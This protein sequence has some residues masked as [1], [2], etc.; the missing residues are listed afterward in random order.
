MKAYR[1]VV[2]T[3]LI[4]GAAVSAQAQSI[5]LNDDSSTYFSV[6]RSYTPAHLERA[7]KNYTGCLEST[8]VGVVESALAHVARMKLIF[9]AAESRKL[10]KQIEFLTVN[11]QTPAIRYKAYL[12][13]MVFDTPEIFG[14]VGQKEFREDEEVFSTLAARLQE[15]LLGYSGE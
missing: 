2:G 13:L 11:G 12:T 6:V 3:L 8:N 15:T 7:V 4:A 5:A 1:V 10:A 9:P 14:Q